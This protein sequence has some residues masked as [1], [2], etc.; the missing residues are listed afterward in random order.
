MELPV[1]TDVVEAAERLEGKAVKT[2]VLRSDW[3]DEVVGGKVL[4]KPENLQ[5][6]GSFKFRGA[7]NFISR[8]DP[9]KNTGGVVAY[10]SGNHAQGVAAA[11]ALMGLPAAIVMPEDSPAIK[12][13]NTKA[14]GAEVVTY[15]RDRQQRDKVAGELVE[16]RNAV[17]VP[18][19]EHRF[20][21]AGQGTLA[22]ELMEWARGEQITIDQMLVPAGGGGLIGGC[23]LVMKELSPQTQ[24]YSVEPN[25]FDDLARSLQAGALLE[26]EAMSGSICDALLT[27]STGEMTFS[28]A[29]RQ[30][31]GGL[32]VSDDEVRVAMRFAFERLK[33][34]IE[35]GGAVA[36]AA[37]LAGKIDAKRNTTAI[38]LSGGNV[39]GAMFGSV[40]T[41]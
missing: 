2:P 36:L 7:W 14:L 22:L 34:V 33:L 41:G 13:A 4:I 3:L 38:V 17:L 21:A 27:P 39:D 40:L 28:L 31:A 11:A 6:T 32:T 10:S 18:P 9:A 25:G 20:I 19:Y 30:L 15:D 12:I 23:G 16:A 5:R 35:P 29:Q 1:F 24:L 26:N 37:L 8:L